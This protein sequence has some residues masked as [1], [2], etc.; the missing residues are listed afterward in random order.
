M[1][2]LVAHSAWGLSRQESA[3]RDSGRVLQGKVTVRDLVFP[4]AAWRWL[5]CA[6]T[7]QVAVAQWPSVPAAA[8]P[9]SRPAL[10]AW[11]GSLRDDSNDSD[12]FSVC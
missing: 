2:M 1:T 9:G 10:L 12:P 3:V 4:V 8:A 6:L 7:F 5:R 11:S